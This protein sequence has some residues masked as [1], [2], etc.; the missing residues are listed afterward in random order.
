GLATDTLQTEPSSLPSP[1]PSPRT[2][3]RMPAPRP[4]PRALAWVAAVAAALGAAILVS[5][6]LT[7]LIRW[8]GLAAEMGS[9]FRR[10]LL[11]FVIGVVFE[12]LRPWR[13]MPRGA[14]G[15]YGETARPLD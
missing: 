15:L 5:G 7:L 6:P 14:W 8:A 9:V 1:R 12:R 2:L 13:E 4:L 3:S 11:V 10:T